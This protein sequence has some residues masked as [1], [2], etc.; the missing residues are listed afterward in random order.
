MCAGLPGT[1]QLTDLVRSKLKGN[2][3]KCYQR[4]VTVLV[5]KGITKPNIEDILS[6]LLHLRSGSTESS[7]DGSTI[8]ETFKK[9]GYIIRSC[10]SVQKTTEYHKQFVR[11]LSNRRSAE[12]A[13]G[14]PPVQI[15]TVNYDLLLECACEEVGLVYMNGFENVFR[16]K[17]SSACFNDE[18]GRLTTHTKNRRF[19]LS[20][21]HIRIFK[22]HGSASWYEDEGQ[23]YETANSS[24]A[25]RMP[26]VIFPSK[27][28]YAESVRPPFDWLYSKFADEVQQAHVLVVIGYRFADDQLNEYIFGRLNDNLS[29]IVF[30]GEPVEVLQSKRRHPR[31]TILDKTQTLVGEQE[32]DHTDLWSFENFVKWLPALGDK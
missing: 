27:F 7:S 19:E 9:I 21:R 6:E 16:R 29:L 20:S 28:K 10:F 24:A 4:I 18:I 11:K 25:D 2:A 17:W 3:V 12:P 30:S 15:F 32:L 5:N 14:A 31:L 13:E 26:L 1:H 8:D 23:F 22:L